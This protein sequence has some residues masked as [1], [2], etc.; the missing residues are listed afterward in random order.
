MRSTDCLTLFWMLRP[1]SAIDTPYSITMS[2]SIAASDSP[3]STLTPCATVF[4]LD[5]P[6]MRCLIEPYARAEPAPIACTPLTSRAASPATFVTTVSLTVIL[7][8]SLLRAVS[9][10]VA[11]V[12]DDGLLGDDEPEDGASED[13]VAD[14]DAGLD[15]AFSFWLL[16]G[17]VEDLVADDGVV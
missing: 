12:F 10:D 8:V 2:R 5:D 16:R 4:V 14:A 17:W 9:V 15:M 1:R 7:P 3:V 13:W 11:G 6:G